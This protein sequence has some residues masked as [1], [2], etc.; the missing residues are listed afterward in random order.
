MGARTGGA[1][2]A[3]TA[4]LVVADL[5]GALARTGVAGR[6]M[7]LPG[8]ADAREYFLDSP[9]ATLV[10]GA[11]ALVA[12]GALAVLAT[13]YRELTRHARRAGP[14][15]SGAVLVLGAAGLA[16][17]ALGVLAPVLPAT[18]VHA[19][20][21]VAAL[22]GGVLHVVTLGLVVTVLA[23]SY[24]WTPGLRVTGAIVGWAAV[25]TLLTLVAA[26]LVPFAGVALLG[27]LVWLAFAAHQ[28]AYAD[29]RH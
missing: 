23:R 8:S 7:P 17:L 25:G 10:A 22:G 6:A 11:M 20:H 16:H 18:A 1:A 3:A 14:I 26:D 15:V 2:V 21:L 4:V 19:L 27:L 24:G 29:Q 28:W 9:V 12:A 5:A 13:A